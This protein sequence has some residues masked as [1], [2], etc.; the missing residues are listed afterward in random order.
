MVVWD[1]MLFWIGGLAVGFVV[2]VVS[3]SYFVDGAK[4]TAHYLRVS[5]LIIGLTAVSI[6]TSAPEIFV[7]IMDSLT[8][9]PDVAI[10]NAIGSN[11]ANIGLVLG[12]TALVVPLPFGQRVLRHELPLLLLA[13]FLAAFC[14]A[15]LIVGYVDG[16]LLLALLG[17]ILYRLIRE[18]QSTGQLPEEIES[19][20]ENLEGMSRRRAWIQLVVGLVVL[21]FSA[22]LIVTAAEHLAHSMGVSEMLIGLTVV[23][24]GTS[25]PELAATMAAAL[26]KSPG[27]AVGNIVGSN[28]LNLLAVLAVPALMKPTGTGITAIE[29][30]R[31]F[32]TMFALTILVALFANGIGAKKIITRS[33]GAV[34]LAS[35]CCYI[36][37]V[38]WQDG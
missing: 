11:I 2:L 24:A 15:N 27:I 4:V 5:E 13:T 26:R 18:S 21:V 23:A 16:I 31:D 36:V 7:A 20:V 9:S 25:L 38:F 19:E 3:A 1:G 6:G 32:G 14:L 29:Y 8:E 10:G 30:W 12:L 35:Y 17:F 33:E 28:I 37:L 34:L 22:K